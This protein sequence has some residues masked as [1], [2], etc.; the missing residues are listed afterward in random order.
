MYAHI[1]RIAKYESLRNLISNIFKSLNKTLLFYMQ[2]FSVNFYRFNQRPYGKVDFLSLFKDRNENLMH[3]L[4]FYS[5]YFE[6]SRIIYQHD[7]L[8]KTQ[9]SI[10]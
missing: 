6:I 4:F 10:L 1:H 2:F 5:K 8:S 7:K 9:K 3:R